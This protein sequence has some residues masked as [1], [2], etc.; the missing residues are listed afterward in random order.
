[1]GNLTSE[2]DGACSFGKPVGATL[3]SCAVAFTT[4]TNDAG[5]W[6]LDAVTVRLGYEIGWTNGLSVALH[7]ADANGKPAA[8]A[9]AA[10]TA[11][12]PKWGDEYTFSCSGSGACDLA[13]NTTYF[14]VLSA[15]KAPTATTANGRRATRPWNTA[16][17]R[18]AAGPSATAGWSKPAT[19]TGRQSPA[20]LP[21]SISPP[22]RPAPACALPD[23]RQQRVAA[24]QR[25]AWYF[26]SNVGPHSATCT[27]NSNRRTADGL[28]PGTYYIYTAY[29]DS[30]CTLPIASV[31]FT[32]VA[33]ALSASDVRDDTAT[34]TLAGHSGNWH[35][36]ANRAP[37]TATAD[38]NHRQPG[39][40]A[41]HVVHLLGVQRQQLHNL[42]ATAAAFTTRATATL[43]VSQESDNRHADRGQLHRQV[44]V[45]RRQVALHRLPQRGQRQQ[46]P[47][48]LTADTEYTFTAYD[49]S[50]CNSADEIA[51]ET[52]TTVGLSSSS[53]TATG[54]TLTIANYTGGWHYK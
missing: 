16:G 12:P 9:L 29:S 17:P 52:F 21:S 4:G 2:V 6:F 11:T 22:A 48:H 32:T 43:S 38:G 30:G 25:T 39:P 45:R 31:A 27:R 5:G 19:A 24:S 42:I 13:N 35:Y 1:M 53:V 37:H 14:I 28:S 46:R 23:N 8:Q 49:A 26:Q 15:P 18:P 20:R 41:H 47:D 50:G 3:Q 10:I 44:V 40:V 34:L 33:T 51:S 54:A 36:Q 7:S